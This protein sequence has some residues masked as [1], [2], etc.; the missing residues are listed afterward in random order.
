MVNRAAR[1]NRVQ[2]T[3]EK[4]PVRLDLLE[5]A[6]EWFWM[7]GELPE[8]DDHIAREVVQQALRGGIKG[9]PLHEGQPKLHKRRDGSVYWTRETP[10][11][12]SKPDTVRERLFEEA[13]HE[14]PFLRKA[15]RQAIT[16][17]VAYG[18]KVESAAFA[19]RHGL[20]FHMSTGMHVLGYPGRWALPPYEYEA[21]RLFVRFDELSERIAGYGP[22]WLTEQTDFVVKFL[23]TGELPENELRL[24]VMLAQVE[25]EQL[26]LHKQK[27]DVSKAMALFSKLTRAEDDERQAALQS[28]CALAAAGQL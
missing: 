12:Q 26:V 7:F 4:A 8:E 23:T 15:A 9:P 16:V 22:A 28:L 27:R 20:P 17:E 13:M 3:I 5:E 19:A 18:G 21:K 25:L 24:E 1:L 11:V 14:D 6:Y 2:H 10:T